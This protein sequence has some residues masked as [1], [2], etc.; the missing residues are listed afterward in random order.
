M[1]SAKIIKKY[2]SHF[3]KPALMYLYGLLKVVLEGRH[4]NTMHS[5]SLQLIHI[6]GHTMHLF[7]NQW[8]KKISCFVFLC[9]PYATKY[10]MYQYHIQHPPINQSINHYDTPIFQGSHAFL[11]IIFQSFFSCYSMTDKVHFILNYFV[12]H[13][14]I[15]FLFFI[16]YI[17]LFY[18]LILLQSVQ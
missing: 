7:N 11:E 2:P 3:K 14:F 10:D 18:L 4:D 5:A 8:Q 12:V 6:V 15:E 13:Y 17:A 1:V 9:E 16:I